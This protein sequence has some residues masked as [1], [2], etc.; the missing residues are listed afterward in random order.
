MEASALDGLVIVIIGFAKVTW[1]I[2]VPL[3]LMSINKKLRKI[4]IAK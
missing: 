2:V 1:Y 4:L 3:I